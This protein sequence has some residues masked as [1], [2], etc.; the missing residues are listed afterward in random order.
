MCSELAGRSLRVMLPVVYLRGDSVLRA[1]WE[2][3]EGN[4]AS[5]LPERRLCAQ[6]LL[7][8]A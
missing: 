3:F 4:G 5:G 7:G 2:E 6:S 1:C 8:G